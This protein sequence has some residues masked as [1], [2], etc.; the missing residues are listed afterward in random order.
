M[1]DGVVLDGI[2]PDAT[3]LGAHAYALACE[4]FPI[5]RSLTGDGVRQ[6][7]AYLKMIAVADVS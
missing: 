5:C 7:L 3:S 6:T 1:H 2:L 4:L